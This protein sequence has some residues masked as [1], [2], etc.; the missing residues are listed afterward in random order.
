MFRDDGG[1][2]GDHANGDEEG[3]QVDEDALA[4]IRA[5]KKVNDMHKA[6]KIEKKGGIIWEKHNGH[7][8][9]SE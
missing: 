5:K 3:N 9:R 1:D 4:F 7:D 2:D 8:S 6:K